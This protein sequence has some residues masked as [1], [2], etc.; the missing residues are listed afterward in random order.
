MLQLQLTTC[1]SNEIFNLLFVTL[2][3]V[4]FKFRYS[5]IC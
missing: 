1:V 5:F 2:V 3:E 4:Y